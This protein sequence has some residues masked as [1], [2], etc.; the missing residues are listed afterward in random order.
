MD[1]HKIETLKNFLSRSYSETD[2]KNLFYWFNSRKGHSE[3]S[4][5]LDKNWEAFDFDGNIAVD[6]EKILANIK[7]EIRHRKNRG[8]K[9]NFKHFLPYAA[10]FAA[11]LG[12]VF[13]L[14]TYT[15]SFFR[16]QNQANSMASVITENGQR[17]KVILPDSSVVWL[18]SGSQLS[19]NSSSFSK[20]RKVV[21]N[22]QAFFQVAKN[23]Q[24]PFSVES[25]DL[26][27]RVLGTRFDVEFYPE[28]GKI[29]VALESGKV[30]LAHRRIESFNYALSPGE[31]AEFDMAANKISISKPDINK[32]T[33]WKDGVLLFKND[34][35]GRV[36]EKLEKW[37]N[38]EIVVEDAEVYK[39]IFTGTIRN[40]N[41]EQIFRLI[42][43][44]CP[45]K[46]RVINSP[47]PGRIPVIEISGK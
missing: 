26:S 6:S 32:Y 9:N 30:Q 11:I 10:V 41:Y 17:S 18:N 29:S 37:Y 28:T 5:I 24:K 7:N 23:S 45:V 21:L 46:C 19:Y 22:G 44:S 27:I 20:N 38:I 35:M 25:G 1:S 4:R 39:S 42:E 12:L 8:L 36:F 43:Y 47:D 15:G 3:I 13:F 14:A 40:E 16:S 34:P 31:L 33:S 2:L